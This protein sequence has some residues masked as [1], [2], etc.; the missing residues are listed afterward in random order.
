MLAV[1]QPIRLDDVVFLE[2]EYGTIEE[3]TTTYVVIKLWDWRRMV[4]P[5][6]YFIEKPFQN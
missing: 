2:N 4:V 1:T 5:L 6:I 3:I